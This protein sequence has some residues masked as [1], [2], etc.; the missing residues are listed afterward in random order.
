MA[1]KVANPH[2]GEVPIALQLDG[3]AYDL[4]MRPT[5]TAAAEIEATT[6]KGVVA[7]LR[8]I[9]AG[10]VQITACA[11]VVV[12]G[13]RAADPKTDPAKARE[14]VFQTGV[15]AVSGAVS[16]FI[17]N[18]INGGKPLESGAEGEAEAEAETPTG[19]PSAA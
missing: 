14:M 2:R 1:E 13:L 8:E 4:V 12:A 7:I 11:A 6:G 19:T 17:G 18:L 9:A 15:V 5:F 10:D 16:T 3:K